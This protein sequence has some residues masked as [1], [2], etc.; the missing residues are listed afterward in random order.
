MLPGS[1]G[2]GKTS[3][4]LGARMRSLECARPDRQQCDKNGDVR[5]ALLS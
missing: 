2:M 4:S 3:A 5:G 1:V